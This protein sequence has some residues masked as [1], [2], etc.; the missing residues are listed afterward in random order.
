MFY[1]VM[2]FFI[3]YI[4]IIFKRLKKYKYNQKQDYIYKLQ[5]YYIQTTTIKNNKLLLPSNRPDTLFLEITLHNSFRTY[6]S[7]PYIEIDN[8]KHFF[9]F[10]ANGVRYLNISH[11]KE[12]I[13]TDINAIF[14]HKEMKL[15]GFDNQIQQDLQTLIIAPHADDAELSAFGLYSWLKSVNIVTITAGENGVCNYCDI[16]EDK[17]S[18][19]LKKGELRAFD[20]ITTPLLGGLQLGDSH[21]LGYFG[22]RLKDMRKEP[23]KEFYSYL[24]TIR[25]VKNFRKVSHTHIGL[26]EN[27]SPT[28]NNLKKD[29]KEILLT[30]KPKIIVTPHPMIDS[31]PDHKES[32]YLLIELV[33][34]LNLEIKLLLYTNH[35]NISELYP[36]GEMGSS[37]TLPP[38]FQEGL[39]FDSIFS[40]ELNKHK[41]RDKYFA[42]ES[43]HD[44]RD[45]LLAISFKK[46]F[47]LTQKL[48]KTRIMTKDK[49][50]FRRAVRANE[51]FFV[52]QKRD[53]LELLLSQRME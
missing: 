50:Y 48:F 23:H 2:L 17:E 3:L 5:N 7:K 21:A 49:S 34:E 30:T 14:N 38:L 47:K 32:T 1:L 25:S 53:T 9:E 35:L 37:I 44:L 24:E 31:H 43:M 39:L 18:A 20:A 22:S 8:T 4:F 6:F 13:V 26:Q 27:P 36:H 28:F 29:L 15:Y 11:V 45:S 33:L 19:A 10:A 40:F 51:L 46:A 16:Y 41:Q 12:G 52:V 42:I